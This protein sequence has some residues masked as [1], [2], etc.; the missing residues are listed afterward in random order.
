METY[1]RAMLSISVLI[2]EDLRVNNM[3]VS[4]GEG[5]APQL[6]KLVSLESSILAS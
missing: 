4:L 1:N 5:E 6:V 2:L 3:E